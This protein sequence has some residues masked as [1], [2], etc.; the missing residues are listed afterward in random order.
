MKYN[1]FGF[2]QEE[3]IKEKL[4]LNSGLVL[5]LIDKKFCEFSSEFQ[6]FDNKEYVFIRASDIQ[7][8]IPIVGDK[9]TIQRILSNLEYRGYVK[10]KITTLK[11]NEKGKFLFVR[12]TK[13]TKSMRI[14]EVLF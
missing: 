12:L 6:K 1:V 11:R 4:S 9:G 7:S 3:M 8:E 14:E 5:W 2:K 13:K 10:K